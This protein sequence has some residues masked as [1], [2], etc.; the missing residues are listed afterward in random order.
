MLYKNN[1]FPI[2]VWEDVFSCL[3]DNALLIK[4]RG[5]NSVEGDGSTSLETYDNVMI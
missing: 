4:R 3:I 5:F 2:F 1:N